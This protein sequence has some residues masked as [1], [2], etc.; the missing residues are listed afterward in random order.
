MDKSRH[1]QGIKREVG[2]KTV[3]VV[4]RRSGPAIREEGELR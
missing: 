4:P 1:A 3:G 2:E